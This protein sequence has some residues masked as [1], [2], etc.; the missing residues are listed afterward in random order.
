VTGN[1]TTVIL[2]IDHQL[3]AA[4]A[5]ALHLLRPMGMFWQSEPETLGSASWQARKR[6]PHSI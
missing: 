4:V 2:P 5:A 1:G 3:E 6:S